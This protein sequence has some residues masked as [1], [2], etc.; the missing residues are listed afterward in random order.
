AAWPHCLVPVV[1]M[2]EGMEL[3]QVDA[4]DL[5]ALEGTMNVLPRRCGTSRSGLGRQEEV[6]AMPRH[7]GPDAQLRIAIARCG[8]DVIDPVAQQ[9]FQSAVGIVLCRP[10]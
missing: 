9:Q 3:D 10:R 8:V 4:I 1:R 7:P 5:Q 2:T 6:V